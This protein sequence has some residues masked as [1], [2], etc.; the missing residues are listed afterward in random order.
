MT[1]ILSCGTWENHG[2]CW[3]LPRSIKYVLH[4]HMHVCVYVFVYIYVQYMSQ[5]Y[6]VN[7][8]L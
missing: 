4:L 7:I 5:L 1:L 6:S 8:Y 3:V 2:I